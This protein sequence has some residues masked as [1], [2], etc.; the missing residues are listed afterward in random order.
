MLVL[1][2]AS[3]SAAPA[4]TAEGHISEPGTL[5]QFKP[6]SIMPAL[7]GSKWS[8]SGKICGE[9]GQSWRGHRAAHLGANRLAG[10]GGWVCGGADRGLGRASGAPWGAHHRDAVPWEM[11]EEGLRGCRAC[12]LS[13]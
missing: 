9:L 8:M 2:G 10:C 6:S 11:L 1:G 13:S 12:P 4:G 5:H 7:G 3:W